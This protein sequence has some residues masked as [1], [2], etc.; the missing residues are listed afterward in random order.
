MARRTGWE[1]AYLDYETL[2]MLL[3]QIEAVYEDEWHRQST[4]DE[5][6]EERRSRE[7]KRRKQGVNNYRDELF[8]ESDSDLAFASSA[9]GLLGGHDSEDTDEERGQAVDSGSTGPAARKPFTLSYSQENDSSDGDE[10]SLDLDDICGRRSLTL[11]W[12]RESKTAVLEEATAKKPRKKQKRRMM[13][14]PGREQSDFFVG[15]HDEFLVE[16]SEASGGTSA[17]LNTSFQ[18]GFSNENSA[19]L[20][21]PQLEER[22]NFYSFDSRKEKLT[23]PH[24]FSGGAYYP[25]NALTSGVMNTN[26]KNQPPVLPRLTPSEIKRG[27]LDAE[28]RRKTRQRRR[29]KAAKRKRELERRVP[30]HLRVAHA[31]ARSITERFVGLLRA[32]VEK[33]TL[34]AQSRLGELADGYSRCCLNKAYFVR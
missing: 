21:Q 1:R 6:F 17:R 25:N 23:P 30:Q 15:G 5:V 28:R 22:G 3:S 16:G 34:F 31:K 10:D 27:K 29:K 18:R 33:V 9:S 12:R 32:E 2:K 20:Q 8:L 14:S 26:I 19:L 7:R 24:D 11:G 4:E 13:V